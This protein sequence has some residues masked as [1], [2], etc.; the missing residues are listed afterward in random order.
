MGKIVYVFPEKNY[1]ILVLIVLECTGSSELKNK[2]YQ[3]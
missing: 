3:R 1:A 2:F